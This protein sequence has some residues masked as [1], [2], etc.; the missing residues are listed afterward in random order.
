MKTFT[1]VAALN[2]LF[3]T[4][5]AQYFGLLS[6]RSASPIHY[7]AVSASNQSLW[8]NKPTASYC[9]PNIQEL[10]GCPPGNSTNFAGGD[11]TLGMG[12]SVPGGQQVYIDAETGAVKY[13][14]AHSAAIPEGD[15]QTGWNLTYLTAPTASPSATSRTNSV[16]SSLALRATALLGRCLSLSSASSLTM[17]AWASTLLLPTLLRPLLGSTLRWGGD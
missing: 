17:S 10:G 9:P 8:L 1:T 3:L 5:S 15:I 6:V 4:T 14:I 2:T 13:T 11:N 16:A 7:A 12:T